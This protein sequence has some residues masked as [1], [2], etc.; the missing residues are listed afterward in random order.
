MVLERL[1]VVVE[2]NTRIGKWERV[3]WGRGDDLW[4]FSVEGGTRKKDNI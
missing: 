1:N 4:D 2:K 3:Y